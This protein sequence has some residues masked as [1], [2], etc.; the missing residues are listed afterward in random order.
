VDRSASRVAPT[1]VATWKVDMYQT[2]DPPTNGD[3]PPQYLFIVARDRP[4]ILERARER[5]KNDP[6]IEV[7]IDRRRGER[8]R[9][10]SNAG[11]ASERRRAERRRPDGL[12]SDLRVHPALVVQKAPESVGQL[13]QRA[14]DLERQCNAVRDE[15]RRLREEIGVLSS[16]LVA[17]ATA[18]A[19]ANADVTAALAEAE[20]M[21]NIVHHDTAAVRARSERVV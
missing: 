7:I 15:N 17:L 1:I 14:A 16:K 12:G 11:L 9:N 20:R 6:R 2:K 8:R 18:C 3:S 19:T 21:F 4:N 10:S 13:Q 5:F